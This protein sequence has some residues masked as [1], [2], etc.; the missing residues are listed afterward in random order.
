MDEEL[1]A[2]AEKLLA[3][4]HEYYGLMRKRGLA[5]GCIWLTDASGAMIVFT[6]GEYKDRLLYNIETNMD[7]KR[8]YS[9]G[10]AELPEPKS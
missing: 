3:V 5:G 4:A 8:A 2:S 7:A 6:R 1:T 9:F 10:A